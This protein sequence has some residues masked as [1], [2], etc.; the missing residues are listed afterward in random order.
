MD[1]RHLAADRYGLRLVLT[2]LSILFLSGCD[3]MFTLT[4]LRHGVVKE[5]NPLMRM[6]IEYDVQM[7]ANV[8]TALTAS[9]LMLLV[10]CH[11]STILG[12]ISVRSIIT[13]LAI[14]YAG[15]VAYEIVLLNLFVW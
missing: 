4:L 11:G 1:P 8:K 15:L 14:G 10:P 12:R 7:F 6:L 2:I 9:A 13:W 5:W 3:A